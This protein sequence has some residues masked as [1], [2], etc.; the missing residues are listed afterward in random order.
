GVDDVD[1]VLLVLLLGT[2]PEGGYSSRGN[3][4][5][6]LLLLSHPVSGTGAIMGF[7]HLVVDA[8]VEQDPLRGCGFARIDVRTNTDISVQIDRGCTSHDSLLSRCLEAIVR[9]GFVGFSHTVHVFTLLD[10]RTFAFRGVS[11][12]PARRRSIDFSPR[13]RAASTSQRI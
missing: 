9:K 13:L 7:T 5:T 8:G 2:L 6:T 12:S 10:R 11:S 4:N 3:G 1:P